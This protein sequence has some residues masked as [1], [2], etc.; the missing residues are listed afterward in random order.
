M[1]MFEFGGLF[2][3]VVQ[4]FILEGVCVGEDELLNAWHDGKNL[5]EIV[6]VEFYT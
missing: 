2:Y 4:D 3:H 1:E 6:F 5:F